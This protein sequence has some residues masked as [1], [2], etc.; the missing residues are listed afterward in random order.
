[1]AESYGLLRPRNTSGVLPVDDYRQMANYVGQLENWRRSKG[2]K[3]RQS[4]D[5][6]K[7]LAMIGDAYNQYQP[8]ETALGMMALPAKAVVGLGKGMADVL[9]GA[10]DNPQDTGKVF[11]LASMVAGGGFGASKILGDVPAGSIGMFAKTKAKNAKKNMAD[12]LKFTLEDQ[13]LI[14]SYRNEKIKKLGYNVRELPSN[15]PHPGMSGKEI[16]SLMKAE[17]PNKY[18]NVA[19]FE[20]TNLAKSAKDY[21]GVTNNPNETGYILMDGSRLDLSG[22]HYAGGYKKEGN[23]FVPESGKTDYLGGDRAVDHRELYD[24]PGIKEG[25]HQWSAVEQLMMDTGA[26][27]YLPNQG[28]SIINGQPIN[29]KQLKS[30]VRDFRKTGNSMNVDIDPVGGNSSAISKSF[31]KPTLESVKKF[32]DLNK[33]Q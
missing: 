27:R 5:I 7:L 28:F 9:K 1:M 13:A 4:D 8:P 20:D 22:R 33:L 24:L 14:N 29:D 31:K 15:A 25:D 12:T 6:P 23:K 16:R 2:A 3:K 18:N 11:D 32:I 26:V 21:F 30:I 17:N 10:M 19:K